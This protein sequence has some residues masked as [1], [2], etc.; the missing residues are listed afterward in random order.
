MAARNTGQKSRAVGPGGTGSEV[1]RISKPERLLNL[2]AFLLSSRRA[3][4]FARIRGRVAGYD[5]P[6]TPE[7]LEKRFDRDKAELRSLGVPIVYDPSDEQGEEGYRIPREQYFLPDVCLTMEEA[8]ALAVVQRYAYSATGDPLAGFLQSALRKVVVDS[9]LTGAA[10]ASVTEQHRLGVRTTSGAPELGPNLEALTDGVIRHQPVRFRYYSLERDSVEE[11][12]VEPYG[13]GWHGRWW[14]V[15]GLDRK[16]EAVRQF[17]V[18]R[19]RGRV[20]V[21]SAKPFEVPED[22]DVSTH[23]GRPAFSF[24]EGESVTVTVELRPEIAFLFGEGIR[25]GWTF[26]EREDGSALL[27]FPSTH[28][29]ATLRYVAPH[30]ERVRIVAPAKV[31]DEAREHFRAILAR[32]EGAPTEV[33]GRRAGKARR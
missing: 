17:R 21:R 22:F 3:V 19:I 12:E 6:A 10:A 13:L 25:E 32:H 7:A 33:P 29:P 9:P 31:R 11:R 16:R 5:D 28:T 30:G 18:D 14:Y 23:I 15:V 4:P 20:K 1:T 8:A 26:T 2:V 24:H 27:T